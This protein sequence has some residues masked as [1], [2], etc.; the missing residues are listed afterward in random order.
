MQGGTRGGQRH[1][2]REALVSSP[3]Q[4]PRAPPLL[5]PP[6][7]E[8][9]RRASLQWGDGMGHADELL[10]GRRHTELDRVR[11]VRHGSLPSHPSRAASPRTQ[12]TLLGVYA[13][14]HAVRP[15]LP[16]SLLPRLLQVLRSHLPL[17]REAFG[18]FA[19]TPGL[20]ATVEAGGKLPLEMGATG[21]RAEA[22]GPSAPK[23]HRQMSLGQFWR[24]LHES[25]LEPD[26]M[27]PALPAAEFSEDFEPLDEGRLEAHMR[28][29][30]K[31]HTHVPP[32]PPPGPLR[33]L[34]TAHHPLRAGGLAHVVRALLRAAGGGSSLE[35]A[36]T[37]LPHER[38]GRL[39]THHVQP[40]MQRLAPP[41]PYDERAHEQLRVPVVL[42]EA[43]AGAALK[44]VAD[45]ADKVQRE[46]EPAL[47]AELEAEVTNIRAAL[48]LARAELKAELKVAAA[49]K[50]AAVAAEQRASDAEAR[51]TRASR[52]TP[53][54]RRPTPDA[55]RPTPHAPRHKPQPS[56]PIP[57]GPRPRLLRTPPHPGG[58]GGAAARGGA[59]RGLRP[60]AGRGGRGRRER[61]R[62]WRGGRG[63]RRLRGRR[64][65]HRA[66][67]APSPGGGLGRG[68]AAAPRRR[69]LR[70]AAATRRD[71][72]AAAGAGP[73]GLWR[74]QRGRAA[75]RGPRQRR[76]RGA[77][78][79]ARGR[80]LPRL[81]QLERPAAPP[82][83]DAHHR[84]RLL[85]RG[86]ERSLPRGHAPPLRAAR[87][88]R[89]P[90]QPDRVRHVGAPRRATRPAA[91]PISPSAAL[92]ARSPATLSRRAR[93]RSSTGLTPHAL[94]GQVRFLMRLSAV[95]LPELGAARRAAHLF[96]YLLVH[97]RI[98]Q[99]ARRGIG[100]DGRRVGRASMDA[101]DEGAARRLGDAGTAPHRPTTRVA[102]ADGGRSC[103]GGREPASSS[104]CDAA[105][106]ALPAAAV[107]APGPG[108]GREHAQRR[109]QVAGG[110]SSSA[111]ERS[112]G[113]GRKGRYL[114]KPAGAREES[115][116]RA[117]R[118]SRDSAASRAN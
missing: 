113:R 98:D 75:A 45:K 59:G 4:T 44:T 96:S 76:R 14:C 57:K 65:R 58:G 106:A 94:R 108:P 28:A 5:E 26:G 54:A 27:P 53:D 71:A 52:P 18:R 67:D 93:S 32:L 20:A 40:M 115:F 56:A 87:V 46:V 112:G 91:P 3:P 22:G 62:R 78:A 19:D 10:H 34:V 90:R 21:E 101:A 60:L 66:R 63:G 102:T 25:R 105:A 12:P 64:G 118:Y 100:L 77:V 16:P 81:L 99:D 80:R 69:G 110:D 107:P 68:A 50:A 86:R 15:S 55:P 39:L 103:A 30:A 89:Q 51:A 116:S 85:G 24:L 6:W 84:R 29:R 47:K 33:E 35:L 8:V 1:G 92:A 9:L 13:A 36:S 97:T 48:E 104:R 61:E 111:S 88:R 95:L 17:L 83:G 117:R 109:P 49:A 42:M 74:R 72:A 2:T 114:L 38:F 11:E 82:A 41:P 79:V 73:N 7:E 23:G 37:P 31:A 70:P 43:E